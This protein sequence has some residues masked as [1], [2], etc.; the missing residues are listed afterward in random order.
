MVITGMFEVASHMLPRTALMR[1]TRPNVNRIVLPSGRSE[2][3]FFDD[4]LPCFG[5]SRPSTWWTFQ[6]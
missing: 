6:V 5:G 4:T 1:L 3:I 2:Q